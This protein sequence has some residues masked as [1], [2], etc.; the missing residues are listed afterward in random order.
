MHS[1]QRSSWYFTGLLSNFGQDTGRET[2][3]T[4]HET[5]APKSCRYYWK[6]YFHIFL[7]YFLTM[8]ITCR[9]YILIYNEIVFKPQLM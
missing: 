2:H 9:P 6:S 1:Y 4:L 5:S 8:T 3:M 7:L